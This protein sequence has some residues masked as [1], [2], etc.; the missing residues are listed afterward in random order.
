MVKR[1]ESWRAEDGQMFATCAE[2]HLHEATQS[3]RAFVKNAGY[4]PTVALWLESN[5]KEVGALLKHLET[6]AD[7]V[8]REQ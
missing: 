1:V 5:A 4:G 3:L 7:A 6:A 8:H 2:A